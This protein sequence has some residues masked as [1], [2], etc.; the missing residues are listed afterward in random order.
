[1][2]RALMLMPLLLVIPLAPASA[3]SAKSCFPIRE[4]DGWRAQDAKTIF[5]RVS[6]TRYYRLDLGA[7]CPL[8]MD[9]GAHLITSSRGT[10][11]MC[12]ADDW[13]L[14]VSRD[15][16]GSIPSPCIVKTM[17]PLTQAEADAIPKEFKPQ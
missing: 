17:T 13:D 12:G 5:I 1:M 11:F 8:V 2:T 3:D 6:Q 4:F 10:S 16:I 15:T 9:K 7:A 14:K